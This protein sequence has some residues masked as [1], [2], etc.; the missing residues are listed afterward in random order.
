MN[1]T[2]NTNTQYNSLEIKFDEKPSSSILNA[3]KSF[4][5]RWNPKKSIWYGFADEKEI[6]EAIEG[7]NT[8]KAKS[9]T[10]E[11]SHGIKVGDIFTMSWG[12]DQTNVDFFQVTKVSNKCVWVVE[13]SLAMTSEDYISSMSADRTYSTELCVR[14]ER[15]VFINDQVDGDR[16]TIKHWG[17]DCYLSFDVGNAH[18]YSGEKLYESWHA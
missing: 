2:I 16:K 3:L 1:Y 9:D 8:R 14:R 6:R 13:V 7:G 11:Y 10:V 17:D 5:F 4:K 12:Y 18:K 15:S